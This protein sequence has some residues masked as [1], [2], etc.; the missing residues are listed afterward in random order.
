[1]STSSAILG[2]STHATTF[3]SLMKSN[4]ISRDVQQ[5]LARVFGLVSAAIAIASIGCALGLVIGISSGAAIL[6][7]SIGAIA[8]L[9]CALA[10]DRSAESL[11][12]RVTLFALFSAFEGF[13]LTPIAR[14]LLASS[15]LL[16]FEVLGLSCAVFASFA[17]AALA[18]RRR[19]Y[20]ALYGVLGSLSSTLL[21]VALVNTF[22]VRSSGVRDAEV[23]LGLLLSVGFT[24]VHTQLIVERAS[25]ASAEPDALADASQLFLD[26][27]QIFIRVA[28]M[29]L[30]RRE[31]GAGGD[32]GGSSN[33]AGLIRAVGGSNARDEL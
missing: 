16:V 8:L 20:I 23:I 32:N 11:P 27:V 24:A 26:L 15:P 17:G 1:M 19:A 10:T 12:R 21:M 30:R 9:V 22:F 6:L 25:V 5:H 4:D 33:A 14:A 13:A 7:G 18:S 31:G 29:M 28:I 3:S 2:G